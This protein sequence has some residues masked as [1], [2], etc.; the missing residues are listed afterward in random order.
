MLQR[1]Q[2]RAKPVEAL[3]ASFEEEP[4]AAA[5][6]AQ[7]HRAVLPEGRVVAV[8]VRRPDIALARRVLDGWEP[9]ISIEEGLA[10]THAYFVAELAR[11]AGGP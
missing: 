6:V 1:F 2:I 4:V 7:V 5:S 3:F 11:K 9:R 10:R 8:K